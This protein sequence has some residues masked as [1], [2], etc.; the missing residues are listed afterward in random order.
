MTCGK[1]LGSHLVSRVA[2]NEATRKKKEF[3]LPAVV[4]VD[5]MLLVPLEQCGGDGWC[6]RKIILIAAT[7]DWS[8]YK[9]R[10][11]RTVGRCIL[12]PSRVEVDTAQV[13]CHIPVDHQDSNWRQELSQKYLLCR[14]RLIN[15]DILLFKVV[16][17]PYTSIDQT[18][19]IPDSRC[20]LMLL[21][22]RTCLIARHFSFYLPK[23]LLLFVSVIKKRW[24][25]LFQYQAVVFALSNWQ[26]VAWKMHETN[27]TNRF[28]RIR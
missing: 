15:S 10:R 13:I 4:V 22:E 7:P 28:G 9:G 17:M 26:T 5:S 2:S 1:H 14:Y 27:G 20:W 8:T 12:V 19:V 16:L 6:G 11:E 18:F 21:T 23:S 24:W 25:N 3:F